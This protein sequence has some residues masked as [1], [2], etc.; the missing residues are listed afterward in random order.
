MDER[1]ANNLEIARTGKELLLDP[2]WE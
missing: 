2:E 1:E